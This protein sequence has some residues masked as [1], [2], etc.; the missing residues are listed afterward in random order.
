MNEKE[1][2]DDD[3]LKGLTEKTFNLDYLSCK[4]LL[5]KYLQELKSQIEETIF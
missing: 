2:I 5:Y 1:V 3:V 4:N